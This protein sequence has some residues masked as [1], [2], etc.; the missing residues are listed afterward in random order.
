MGFNTKAQRTGVNVLGVPGIQ[1]AKQS[2]VY[3]QLVVVG[4]AFCP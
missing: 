3:K 1:A 2:P 4:Y